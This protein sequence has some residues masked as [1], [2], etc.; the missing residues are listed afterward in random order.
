MRISV[1]VANYNYGK[2]INRTIHSLLNQ[3]LPRSQYEVIVV[4]DGSTDNSLQIIEPFR[5]DIKVIP[6]VHGGLAK[7]CNEAM[8]QAEGQY[9]VRVDSDDYVNSR[10]L[11]IES[12]FLEEN[13]SFDAVSCD[14]Y[15]VSENGDRILRSYADQKPIACGVMFRR[16]TIFDTGLYQDN[17]RI[18]E[19]REFMQRY[20]H[21]YHVYHIPLPLY[22]YLQ[23]SESLTHRE[24]E[25]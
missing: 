11:E 5:K 21:K 25:E 10:M 4:D 16:D 19:E 13:K 24:R 8:R 3:T 22:R 14:Y 1:I 20:Q 17:I 2:Y 7:A 23:H 15:M 18:W 12:L 9:I 6:L